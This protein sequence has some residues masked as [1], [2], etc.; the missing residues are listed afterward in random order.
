MNWK[1]RET[2]PTSW[3]LLFI[4]ILVFDH[5]TLLPGQKNNNV[6]NTIHKTVASIP[7][8]LT[9]GCGEGL[10]NRGLGGLW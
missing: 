6:Q 3:P 10:E 8:H 7:A 4:L 1:G 2:R 9:L 5:G